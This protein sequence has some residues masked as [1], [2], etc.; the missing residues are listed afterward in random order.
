M[1]KINSIWY[2]SVILKSGLLFSLVIPLLLFIIS[3]IT[4]S[5]EYLSLPIKLSS[6]IGVSI[7][8]FLAILLAIELKQDKRINATYSK[9]KNTKIE[10]PNGYYECQNCGNQK[11]RKD[12]KICPVC[13]ISFSK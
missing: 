5:L 13:G 12:E 10:L 6:A 1:K 11:L 7:L 3:K 4:G 9:N 2:G 8:L